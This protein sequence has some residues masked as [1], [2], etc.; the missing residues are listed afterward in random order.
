[1]CLVFVDEKVKKNDTVDGSVLVAY[2]EK[3]SL[4][5]IVFPGVDFMNHMQLYIIFRTQFE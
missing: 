2:I 3:V 1:V 4:L 5:L